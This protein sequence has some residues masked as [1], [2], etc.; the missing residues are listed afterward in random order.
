MTT[1]LIEEAGRKT[2]R[3]LFARYA[4][5]VD[6]DIAA[7]RR[8]AMADEAREEWGHALDAYRIG[9][10]L[11]PGDAELWR[12]LARC[13]AKLGDGHLADQMTRCA[14]AVEGMFK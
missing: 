6:A 9:A 4:G 3:G 7:I 13:Y 5:V 10:V 8:R 2:K 1:E 12:G 11:E 14:L